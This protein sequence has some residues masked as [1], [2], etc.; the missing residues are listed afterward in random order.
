MLLRLAVRAWRLI[1]GEPASRN[2]RSATFTMFHARSCRSVRA[3]RPERSASQ[4]GGNDFCLQLTN[5]EQTRP[6]RRLAL[7]VLRWVISRLNRVAALPQAHDSVLTRAFAGADTHQGVGIF[8]PDL[9][10]RHTLMFY[11]SGFFSAGFRC[12]TMSQ[13]MSRAAKE[14][15]TG[16]YFKQRVNPP[17]NATAV[18]MICGSFPPWRPK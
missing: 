9:P 6:D 17:N 18:G 7:D 3:P 12:S 13:A 11:S 14:M 8:K 4:D 5:E 1:F 10:T 15:G 2:K 16:Q